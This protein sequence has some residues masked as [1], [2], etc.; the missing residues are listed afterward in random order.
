VPTPA[1]PRTSTGSTICGERPPAR[2][3]ESSGQPA[4]SAW[5]IL[6]T[7]ALLVAGRFAPAPAVPLY[8]PGQ[9]TVR[10]SHPTTTVIGHDL[11]PG[12]ELELVVGQQDGY[13]A[14]I[15]HIGNGVFRPIGY[16]LIG[17]E[18]V[19]MAIVP[20]ATE[21]GEAVAVLTANPD[22]VLLLEYQGGLDL[23][24]I[25]DVVALDEDP[26]QVVFGAIGPGSGSGLAV[27]MPGSDRWLLLGP[28]GSD[29]R[30]LQEIPGG[31]RPTAIVLVDLDGDEAP[32]VVTADN[33]YL[34]LALSIFR[35]DGAGDFVMAKQIPAPDA[36]V[37]LFVFDQDDDLID[38]V[39]AAYDNAAFLSVYEPQGGVLVEAERIE[40]A[41]ASDG[42][43]AAPLSGGRKGLWC[44]NAERG[45]VNYYIRA[46]GSWSLLESYYSGGAASDIALHDINHDNLMDLAVANGQGQSV[47][48][49]FGNDN[50]SF[51]AYLATLLSPV[52]NAGLVWDEDGD[53]HL[54]CVVA[55]FGASKL[56]FLRGDGRGHLVAQSPPLVLE[57]AP[58]DLITLAADGDSLLDLAIVQPNASRVQILRRLPGGDYAPLSSVSTGTGPINV[59]AVDF[60]LDDVLDLAVGNEGSDDITVAFGVG[61]GTYPDIHLLPM[62]SQLVGLIP[63]RLDHDALPDLVVTNGLNSVGTLMN[64]GNRVFGQMRFYTVGSGTSALAAADFDQDGDQDV[65]VAK[66]DD[67]GV[68]F[69]ENLGNGSLSLRIVTLFLEDR[70]GRLLI[71]DLDLNGLPDVL[72]AFPTVGKIA[73]LLN[74]GGWIFSPPVRFMPALE[75]YA[76]GVGDFNEDDIPDLLTLDRKLALALV[77]LNI[78]PNPVAIERPALSA[79]CQ[80]GG[81]EVRLHLLDGAPWRLEGET[82]G[83]WILLADQAGVSY[84]VLG[85]GA[86]GR[87]LQLST[88]DLARAG[89]LK[90]G[91]R[92]IAFRLSRPLSGESFTATLPTAACFEGVDVSEPAL[93]TV[94]I[95]EPNPFN[96]AVRVRFD[97]TEAAWVRGIVW[98][99]AGR[100]VAELAHRAFPPGGH[101]LEWDG[102]TTGG[103][104][105]AGVYLVTVEAGGRILS[106][107]VTLLK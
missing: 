102:R 23:F 101:V 85:N 80:G 26:G 5:A 42:M 106:R 25:L 49:L 43:V 64:L 67:R 19:D 3:V 90:D 73:V 45:I 20:D 96:P 21:R 55:A 24:S 50:P 93:L 28:E 11:V 62:A 104:A 61:D 81:V 86:E 70:P 95:P 78:E 107:K 35:K 82:A 31:D 1:S 30:I 53:G 47:A 65:V 38:E 17:G 2:G 99:L 69:L 91:R 66:E 9:V 63:V 56:D 41:I 22:R 92:E 14:V 54:D 8:F 75:P 84:G 13:L 29:W 100:R 57:N 12:G 15:Q 16:K 18:V 32:E 7:A 44:W 27:T 97:L 10:I 76:I 51:R 37:D 68:G 46:D 36:P 39:F 88:E 77:L 79:Y 48:L 4:R 105:G 72:V 71:S 58:R 98:D 33:G 60:D 74:L 34:S 6:A 40:T 52:P 59:Y 83:A 103:R 94:D 87:R 89:I